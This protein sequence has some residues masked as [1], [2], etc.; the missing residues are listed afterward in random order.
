MNLLEFNSIIKLKQD[1][2]FPKK[3]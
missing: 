3:I 2:D 1:Y